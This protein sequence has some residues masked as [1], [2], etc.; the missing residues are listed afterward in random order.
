MKHV[1]I[2]LDQS[3][4]NNQIFQLNISFKIFNFIIRNFS[5]QFQRQFH[6]DYFLDDL[7]F[8]I[9]IYIVKLG[10]LFQVNYSKFLRFP[11]T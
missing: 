6:Q 9:E 10:I 3:L 2:T 1:G 7:L 11:Y 4:Y 5:K 8:Q